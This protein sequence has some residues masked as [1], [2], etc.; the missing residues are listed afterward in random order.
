MGRYLCTNKVWD[1]DPLEIYTDSEGEVIFKKY[2]PLG[3]LGSFANHYA[4]ALYRTTGKGVCITDS[5]TVIAA[6]GVPKKEFVEQ[7][8]TED[9]ISFM[10]DREEYIL[11]HPEDKKYCLLQNNDGYIIG[12][13]IPIIAEGDILGSVVFIYENYNETPTETDY[14]LAKAASIFLG[15]QM[16][17]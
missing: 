14:K 8:I 12:V 2:S 15:R 10:V 7:K 17:E 13:C 11:K 3:E 1:G 6:S 4:E 5:D 16:E 9:V